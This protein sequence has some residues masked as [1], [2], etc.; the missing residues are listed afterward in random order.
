[1]CDWAAGAEL[2]EAASSAAVA[3]RHL[4]SSLQ[5]ARKSNHPKPLGRP[6]PVALLKNAF[7]LKA[8][9]GPALKPVPVS[10]TEK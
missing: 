6:C 4:S 10:C 5:S 7:S 2:R 3:A 9:P 1:M 8:F